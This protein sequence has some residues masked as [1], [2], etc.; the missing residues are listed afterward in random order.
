M[1]ILSAPRP[2][3]PA[4]ARLAQCSSR[5]VGSPAWW[6]RLAR[7][8]DELAEELAELDSEGLAGRIRAVA[9]DLGPSADEVAS[10]DRDLRDGVARMRTEVADNAG[11]V[12]PGF[13]VAHAVDRLLE[14]A[15]S[16]HEMSDTLVQTAQAREPR[17][18]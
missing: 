11:S 15:R 3:S 14:A 1:T 17:P 9:P 6:A 16:L 4:I 10:L 13:R 5:D 18:A 7:H 2:P 12:E 8:L